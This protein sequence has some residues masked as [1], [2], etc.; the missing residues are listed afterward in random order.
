MEI[1]VTFVGC[2]ISVKSVFLNG[3]MEGY[4]ICGGISSILHCPAYK[5]CGIF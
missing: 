2:N 1:F 4:Y 5:F 3:F